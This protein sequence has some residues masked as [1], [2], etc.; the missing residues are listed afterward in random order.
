MKA[1][2]SIFGKPNLSITQLYQK[3]T[4]VQT[5]L[6]LVSCQDEPAWNNQRKSNGVIAVRRNG[7]SGRI[8]RPLESHRAGCVFTALVL[9]HLP[10][11]TAATAAHP[12]AAASIFAASA[13]L[14]TGT[15]LVDIE[16][17]SL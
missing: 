3:Q 10:G 16:C 11:I 8:T 4:A 2:L 17:S 1:V 5:K 9:F 13:T 15:R 6:P 14:R 12:P 7:L